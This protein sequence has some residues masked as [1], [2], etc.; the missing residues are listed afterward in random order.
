MN[1]LVPFIPEIILTSVSIGM[2]T[3]GAVTSPGVPLWL[4]ILIGLSVV[5]LNFSRAIAVFIRKLKK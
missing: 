2:G 1:G 3:Y 5:V 4:I